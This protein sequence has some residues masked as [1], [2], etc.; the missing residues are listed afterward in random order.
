M[1]LAD[2]E[3]SESDSHAFDDPSECD[4]DLC[5]P[6]EVRTLRGDLVCDLTASQ[7][8]LEDNGVPQKP[9]LDT[10][11]SPSKLA[12]VIVEQCSREAYRD[13]AHIKGLPR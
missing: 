11:D 4:I 2:D 9:R 1:F 12:L 3:R 7:F 5:V 13:T 6:T 8:R 10:S